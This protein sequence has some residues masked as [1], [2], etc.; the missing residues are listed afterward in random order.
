[1]EILIIIN[2]LQFLVRTWEKE[3]SMKILRI[4]TNNMTTIQTIATGRIP[5]GHL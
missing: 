4:A 5:D 2:G 1:V 3:S